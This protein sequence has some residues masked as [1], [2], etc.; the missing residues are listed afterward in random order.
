MPGTRGTELG[1][2]FIDVPAQRVRIRRREPVRQ[3]F[4]HRRDNLH[5]NIV[6]RH[7]FYSTPGVPAAGIDDAKY[8]AAD[9]HSRTTVAPAFDGRPKWGASRL[10][11]NMARDEMGM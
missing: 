3:E 4:R 1:Y 5:V 8:L 11:R 9:H 10:R 2:S 7:I 6:G